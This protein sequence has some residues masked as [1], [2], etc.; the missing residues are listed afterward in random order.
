MQASSAKFML[1]ILHTGLEHNLVAEI[2]MPIDTNI[3]YKIILVGNGDPMQ[4]VRPRI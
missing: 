3:K 1:S 2:A 4:E